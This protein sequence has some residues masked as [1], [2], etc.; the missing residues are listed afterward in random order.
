MVKQYPCV[1]LDNEAGLENLSRRIVNKVNLLV[2]VTDQSSRGFETVRRLHALAHEMEIVYDRLAI[3]VNRLR[4]PEL[5][6]GAEEL[7]IATGADAVVGLPED[8]DLLVLSEQGGNLQSLPQKHLL[9][10]G[11]DPILNLLT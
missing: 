4:R 10:T 1:V 9:L 8:G 2:M 7:R 3:L 11:L 5:P 6:A